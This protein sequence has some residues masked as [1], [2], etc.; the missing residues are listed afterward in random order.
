MTAAYPGH[1]HA[2]H[3]VVMAYHQSVASGLLDAPDF[4]PDDW[5]RPEFRE[6]EYAECA[7]EAVTNWLENTPVALAHAKWLTS[8]GDRTHAGTRLAHWLDE[9]LYGPGIARFPPDERDSVQV[10]ADDMA[11]KR[12]CQMDFGALLDSLQE[13]DCEPRPMA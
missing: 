6:G 9:L 8:V 3:Y 4:R 7:R 1:R 5:T 12:F 2:S 10:V 11:R 13:S